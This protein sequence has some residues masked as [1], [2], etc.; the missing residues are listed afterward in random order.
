MHPY[1][2]QVFSRTIDTKV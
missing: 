1:A 2:Y